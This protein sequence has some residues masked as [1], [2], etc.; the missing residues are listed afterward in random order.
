[1][2]ANE[3]RF[4]T[5]L[6]Y[7]GTVTMLAVVAV[8][9]AAAVESEVETMVQT[10]AYVRYVNK[11]AHLSSSPRLVMPVELQPPANCRSTAAVQMGWHNKL[12]FTKYMPLA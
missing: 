9:A 5:Q 6:M 12:P 3:L 4:A 11:D 10:S 1:M 7:V 8:A 2:S